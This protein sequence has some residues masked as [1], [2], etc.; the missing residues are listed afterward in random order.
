MSISVTVLGCGTS[1]GVPIPGCKCPVCQSTHPRNKRLRT[2]IYLRLPNNKVILVD[3]SIDLR[4]QALTFN[5]ERVDAVL[6][7]HAHSDHILGTDD[8][9]CFNFVQRQA[10]PCY[11]TAFTL[12]RIRDTFNYIFVPNP[13]YEGGLLA[14][15]SLN[16]I[17]LHQP[18]TIEGLKIEP[19]RLWH[20]SMEVAG[21][22][23][24]NFA[25]ATDCNRIPDETK[26]LLHGIEW[27]I[28]D[29]LR[30]EPHGTHFTIDQAVAMAKELDAK[31]TYLTHMTHAVDYESTN[32][33]LP[34]GIE[35]AY[36][37]L[38][39]EIK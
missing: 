19:F 30:D 24:G 23:F 37:G 7:T 35:L 18:F 34:E 31:H 5:L 6:Y 17:N 10:I 2:S 13:K 32:A 36:D 25:Y 8:L 39:I 22:K 27:L 12:D 14:N 16:P 38:K 4:M 3:A 20:G 29:G 9:R 15:L 26:Q 11:G 21:F 33:R 28:L 1:T